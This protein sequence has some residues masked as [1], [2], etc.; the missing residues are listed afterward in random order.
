MRNSISLALLLVFSLLAPLAGMNRPLLAQELERPLARRHMA[1]SSKIAA[2]LRDEM[3][4]A[5][6]GSDRARV[7]LNVADGKAAT[8]ARRA[9]E[10]AGA[11]VSRQLDAL[12]VLVA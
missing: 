11:S 2:N 9:L 1:G 3:N 5:R 8:E 6:G 7:I 12:G 4:Q 10:L